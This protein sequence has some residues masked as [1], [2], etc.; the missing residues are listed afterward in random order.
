MK[1]VGTELNPDSPGLHR[2]EAVISAALP[3]TPR[4]PRLR[5]TL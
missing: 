2:R 4:F 5:D 1:A 3:E